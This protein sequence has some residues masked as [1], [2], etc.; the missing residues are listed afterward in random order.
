MSDKEGIEILQQGLNYSFPVLK[1]TQKGKMANLSLRPK[2]GANLS[3]DTTDMH[4]KSLKGASKVFK[5]LTS[6]DIE[7]IPPMTK[8]Q[9]CKCGKNSR[10]TNIT[11]LRR[12]GADRESLS[13]LRCGGKIKA[14]K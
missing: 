11:N 2:L 13:C 10:P 3:V 4:F 1:G 7:G 5:D 6:I 8:G 9:S 12:D 14:G